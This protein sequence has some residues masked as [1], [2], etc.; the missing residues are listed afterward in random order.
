MAGQFI[1]PPTAFSIDRPS[2]QRV[3]RVKLDAH[4]AWIRSLP[5]LVPGSGDVEAAH[6]RYREPLFAKPGTGMGEKPADMWVVPL[7]HTVHM[8]QHTRNEREWWDE[9]GI[10]PVIVAAFLWCHT[11]SDQ[12]GLTII[13]NAKRFRR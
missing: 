8:Q 12:A 13:R 3:P 7:A 2:R 11:G 6:I 5:S 9:H 1:R 10:D 4:L